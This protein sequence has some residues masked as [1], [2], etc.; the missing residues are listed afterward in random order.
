MV[1]RG[2]I[3]QLENSTFTQFVFG[4]GTSNGSLVT[5]SLFRGYAGMVDPNRMLHDEWLRT[6]Y[7]WGLVGTFLWCSFWVSIIA[8]AANGVRNDSIGYAKPLLIYVPALLVALGG[9]NFVAGAGN[10]ANIGFV[11]LLGYATLAHRYPLR[12]IDPLL[13]ETAPQYQMNTRDLIA[14][15]P[16]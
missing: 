3:E 2:A 13:I 16:R 1:Y 6:V 14:R 8:Y 10:A 11:M 9:E 7:E 4:R 5:G 15:V 12:R